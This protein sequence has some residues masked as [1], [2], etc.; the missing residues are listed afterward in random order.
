MEFYVYVYIYLYTHTYMY[1]FYLTFLSH[2][3]TALLALEI[4][5]YL[6]NNFYDW[7]H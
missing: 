1:V 7:V 6:L 5:Q 2:L 4:I 3:I